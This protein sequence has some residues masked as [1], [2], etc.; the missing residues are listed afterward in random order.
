MI[1]DN[2]LHICIIVNV[3]YAMVVN[4]VYYSLD[5]NILLER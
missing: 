1:H 4:N 2:L 5:V 3:L